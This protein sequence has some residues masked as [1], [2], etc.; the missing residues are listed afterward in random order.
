[1]E[2]CG[3]NSCWSSNLLNHPNNEMKIRPELLKQTEK[4]HLRRFELHQ[5]H[6]HPHQ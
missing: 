6:L 1:M 4:D 2:G 5:T 3:V